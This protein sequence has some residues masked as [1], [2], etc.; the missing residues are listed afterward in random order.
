MKI[1]LD[2]EE[3]NKLTRLSD[4]EGHVFVYKSDRRNPIHPYILARVDSQDRKLISLLSGN[5]YSEYPVT[6]A[7]LQVW[8][9]VT[10]LI[11]ISHEW[12]S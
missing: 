3:L 10:D 11:K 12:R 8:D 1:D 9:D 7:D 5:R 2:A 6:E 4:L